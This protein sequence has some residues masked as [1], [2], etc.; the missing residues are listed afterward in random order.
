MIDMMTCPKIFA[1]ATK[2][3]DIHKITIW[4]LNNNFCYEILFIP[5]KPLIIHDE[6][7]SKSTIYSMTI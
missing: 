7:S 2:I 4:N 1:C 6:Q 3:Q 5:L